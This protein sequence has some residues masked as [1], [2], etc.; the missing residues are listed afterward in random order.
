MAGRTETTEGNEKKAGSASARMDGMESIA[1]VS[2]VR[3]LRS[4]LGLRVGLVCQTDDACVGFPLQGQPTGDDDR[5]GNMTCYKGGVTVFNNHQMCDVTSTSLQSCASR[6]R[7][8][9]PR[10]EDPGHA[11]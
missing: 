5:V 8:T 11:A 4:H 7:L 10:P 3:A 9:P 2:N 1:M 6:C